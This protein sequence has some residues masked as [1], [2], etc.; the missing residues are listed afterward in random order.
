MQ[1]EVGDVTTDLKHM[2]IS[3][4]PERKALSKAEAKVRIRPD[5]L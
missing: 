4:K 5:S 1:S 3:S 2:K